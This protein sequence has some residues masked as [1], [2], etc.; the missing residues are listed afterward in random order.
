LDSIGSVERNRAGRWGGDDRGGAEVNS[1]QRDKVSGRY[2]FYLWALFEEDPKGSAN[3]VQ[4]SAHFRGIPAI[5]AA[6]NLV[7]DLDAQQLG[8]VSNNWA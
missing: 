1:L 7:S 3:V 6:K 8:S 4:L 5:M 2:V